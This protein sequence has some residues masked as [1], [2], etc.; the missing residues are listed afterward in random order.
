MINHLNIKEIVGKKRERLQRQP[1]PSLGWDGNQPPQ[2]SQL[3]APDLNVKVTI[4]LKYLS[5]FWRCFDLSLINC[6]IELDLSWAKYC[7]LTEH[8]N[9]ITRAN[10][11]ITSIK[12]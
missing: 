8:D 11:M 2:P 7:V 12:L 9:N 4:P 6:E 3:E 10:F 5:K 1:P